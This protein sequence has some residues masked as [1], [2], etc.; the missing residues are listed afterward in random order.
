V[1]CQPG[2]D[3][4]S[5]IEDAST[6]SVASC[7]DCRNAPAV[8]P[9]MMAVT[10]RAAKMHF[11]M[12]LSSVSLPCSLTDGVCRASDASRSEVLHTTATCVAPGAEEMS[13]RRLGSG[14]RAAAIAFNKWRYR[15]Q[16]TPLRPAKLRITDRGRGH[17]ETAGA[18][19]PAACLD[20]VAAI[21]KVLAYEL[22]WER[23]PL[24]EII[25]WWAEA[26]QPEIEIGPHKASRSRCESAAF[27]QSF[28]CG[29][30]PVKSPP[31]RRLTNLRQKSD[32]S[33]RRVPGRFWEARER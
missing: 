29:G 9:E 30:D 17:E 13:R 7:G 11:F 2:A 22:R 28:R 25:Q 31:D 16:T 6:S 20:A 5:V 1:I 33:L 26:R 21:R 27:T 15:K 12:G 14:P 10:A 3:P 4:I 8:V 32:H 19:R 18:V 23:Q 24:V